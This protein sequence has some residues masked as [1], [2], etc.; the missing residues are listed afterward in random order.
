MISLAGIYFVGPKLVEM[1]LLEITG[2][3]LELFF[4]F[5]K[6]DFHIPSVFIGG[7]GRI[8]TENDASCN[9]IKCKGSAVC[10]WR[11]ELWVCCIK[12]KI[13]NSLFL[14][15]NVYTQAQPQSELAAG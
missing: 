2:I 9:K 15:L 12:N 3:K 6:W 14:N 7:K 1:Y 4:F 13:N 8:S 11:S 10:S 5:F